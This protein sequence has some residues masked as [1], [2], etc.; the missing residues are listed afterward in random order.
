MTRIHT[1]RDPAH[2]CVVQRLRSASAPPREC[3]RQLVVED[4]GTA[5]DDDDPGDRRLHGNPPQARQ[6][7]TTWMTPGNA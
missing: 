6:Y 3:I 5:D 7:S 1:G 4:V 2:F